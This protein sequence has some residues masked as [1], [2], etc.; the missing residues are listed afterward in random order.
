MTILIKTKNIPILRF[1]GFFGEWN[2]NKLGEI[3]EVKRGLASQQLIYTSDSNNGVRLLRI[4]DFLSDNPVFIQETE[5]TKILKV[6]TNDLLIA[7]TGA[8]A[9]II[10]IVPEE[11]NDMPFSYNAP[12]IRVNGANYLFVYYYLKSN[13]ILRQQKKLF[14]G[15][16]QPFLDTDSMRGFRMNTPQLEEQQKIAEFLG[17]VDEWIENLRA[18]KESFESYKKGIMQK[19]FSAKDGQVPEIRFKD[20]CG[21]NFPRWEEKTLGDCL[22]Y[23][24]PT[25]YIVSSTEYDNSYKTPVLTA[26]KSFILGYTNETDG[27][28]EKNLP[29]I[30]FD[31]FTTTT[32]F[33]DFPFKV[34]SSAMKILKEKSNVDIKFIYETMKCINYKIGGHGRHW[35]SK[36]SNI[37]ILLPNIVEQQKIAEFLISIDNLI[38]SKQQQ[39]SQAEKWK[40]GLM[41]GLFI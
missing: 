5:D 6:K 31:D 13:I 2:K 9:G 17:S 11:F 29:V 12:R 19:L 27:I 30:I 35:I 20:E 15:N 16:A 10:F 39:I 7:G 40:K 1:A 37:K 3:A 38:E 18:Q 28:F 25:D 8:T 4:N 22:G 26:G 41:Q 23:E 33:V 24:Q 36:Y 32:Q 21:K 34:K 14:V